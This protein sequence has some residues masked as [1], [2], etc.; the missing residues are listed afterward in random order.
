MKLVDLN[1]YQTD[2][3]YIILLYSGKYSYL[4]DLYDSV[5]KDTAIKLLDTFAGSTIE[6][7]SITDIKKYTT[8]VEVYFRIQKVSKRRRPSLIKDLSL[9]FQTTEDTI[10]NIYERAAK[11]IEGDLGIELIQNGR[12]K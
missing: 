2:L 6:F 11:I 9:E 8:E 7:P 4:P 10:R 1:G 5:G 12:R 3:F